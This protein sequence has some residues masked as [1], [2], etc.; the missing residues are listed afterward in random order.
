MT[1]SYEL[2]PAEA[3]QVRAIL[4]THAEIQDQQAMQ[5]EELRGRISQEDADELVESLE[6]VHTTLTDDCANLRRLADIFQ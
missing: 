2:T 5:N 1:K 6:D 4:Q 3:A